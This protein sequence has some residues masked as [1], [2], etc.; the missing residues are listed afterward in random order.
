VANPRLAPYGRAAREVL[1]ALGLWQV[2]QSR[3]VQGESVGQAMQFV[4]SGHAELGF[5]ALSQVQPGGPARV[6]SYWEIP[7]SLYTPIQ[8]QAVLLTDSPT[9]RA[10]LAFVR[11][12]EAL[13]V[14][15]RYGYG[16][17]DS[18]R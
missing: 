16:V 7:Q 6:G 14:I 3:I 9:A 10:L 12:D 18:D 13:A 15:R 17:P 8:Q 11:S 2:L 5:V 1:E 4:I